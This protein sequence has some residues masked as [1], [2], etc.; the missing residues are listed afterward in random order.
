MQHVRNRW[1]TSDGHWVVDVIR[2]SLTGNNRDGT[3][4]RVRHRGFFAGEVRRWEDLDRFPFDVRD[5]RG[6]LRG[7]HHR[8]L[9]PLG[10]GDPRS[11]APFPGTG[12]CEGAAR[13]S[14]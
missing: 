6:K 8:R 12:E 14:R 1:V 10:S 2:L 3:W 11:S 4:L 9:G 5:L 13:G 7:R